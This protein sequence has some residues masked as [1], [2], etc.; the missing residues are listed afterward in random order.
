[1]L[2]SLLSCNWILH[3]DTVPP[4][5]LEKLLK[6]TSPRISK[7]ILRLVALKAT[8]PESYDHK[9]ATS[10][11]NRLDGLFEQLE[12]SRSALK[13]N[14]SNMDLLNHYFINKLNDPTYD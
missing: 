3:D 13:V 4:M 8:K 2:R 1:M 6:Y 9:G 14:N 7:T 11:F 5:E 10:L 12:A